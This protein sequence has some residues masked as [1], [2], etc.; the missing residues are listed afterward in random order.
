MEKNL[1]IQNRTEKLPC[2]FHTDHSRR[3]GW[4]AVQLGPQGV[5]E[6]SF[7]LEHTGMVVATRREVNYV[8]TEE[9]K[10]RLQSRF[11]F[12]ALPQAAAAAGFRTDN[13]F[14]FFAALGNS[15]FNNVRFLFCGFRTSQLASSPVQ[16]VFSFI[17]FLSSASESKT[18]TS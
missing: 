15:D 1:R 5:L 17:F 14:S 6:S 7:V 11:V 8:H 4:R 18:I 10:R 16:V 9:K 3:P 12:F 13:G 2:R